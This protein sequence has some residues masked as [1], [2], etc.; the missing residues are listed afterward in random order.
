MKRLLV[1]VVILLVSLTAAAPSSAYFADF[2]G[3]PN[4][5]PV[6]YISN[7]PGM[8]FSGAD[9]T[10]VDLSLSS[11]P[12]FALQGNTIGGCMS[13]LTIEFDKA[14]RYIGFDFMISDWENMF[15]YEATVTAT[16]K[17][18]I[19]SSASYGV[20]LPGGGYKFPEGSA[21]LGTRR[22]FDAVIVTHN[23]PTNCLYI[24]NI[25]TAVRGR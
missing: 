2:S 14:Q 6:H 1:A 7:I 8:T 21:S 9:W 16:F 25:E 17:G 11:N 24:D 20:A 10:V 5:M 3:L 13:A 18:R 15:G 23:A 12:P 19:V 22:P 4:N